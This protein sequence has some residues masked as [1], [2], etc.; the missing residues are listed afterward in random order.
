[1]IKEFYNL[2]KI[3]YLLLTKRNF[4]MKLM[5]NIEKIKYVVPDANESKEFWKG[6]WSEPNVSRPQ[7]YGVNQMKVDLSK[8]RYILPLRKYII[9]AE[10]FLIGRHQD[11]MEFTGSG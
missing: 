5:E 1:M 6:I 8:K 7:V 10:K 2:G 3:G 11:Q 9:N 4:I